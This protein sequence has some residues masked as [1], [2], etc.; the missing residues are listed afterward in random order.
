LLGDKDV[1]VGDNAAQALSK[2]KAE[3]AIPGLM[4]LLGDKD[5]AVRKN[6]A[7][8]LGKM[9]AEN[10]IP[11]L[12]KMLGIALEMYAVTQLMHWVN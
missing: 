4:Q 11:G 7:Q 10:A 5:A 9:K 12:I 2:M 8:A 3:N 1:E 6:A